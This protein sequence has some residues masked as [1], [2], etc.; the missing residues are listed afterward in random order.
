MK[1]ILAAVPCALFLLA[2][3][4]TGDTC[5][6]NPATL[7]NRSASSCSV[8]AGQQVTFNVALNCNCTESTPS[9]QAEIVNNNSIEVAPVFQLC[10]ADAAC[11]GTPGC[12]ITRPTASCSVTIPAN[13][14]GQT[15]PLTVVGDAT[16][17]GGAVSIGAGG[18][19]CDL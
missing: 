2:A 13:L 5:Q 19:S 18:T 11:G 4:G 3:C 8:A 9:C 14:S 10:Q 7:Q 12:A 1:R 17:T 15:L 16:V 6:T